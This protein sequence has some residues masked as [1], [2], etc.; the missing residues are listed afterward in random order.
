MMTRVLSQTEIARELHVSKA[1]ISSDMQYLRNEPNE[2]IREHTIEYLPEQ[3]HV[4]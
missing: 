2:S 3:Y 4:L 1:S